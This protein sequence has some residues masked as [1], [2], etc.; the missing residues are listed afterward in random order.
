M[1]LFVRDV[2]DGAGFVLYDLALFVGAVG[3]AYA[4][5]QFV[6]ATWRD[7]GPVPPHRRPHRDPG[8]ARH[9]RQRLHCPSLRVAVRC[10]RP[11]RLLRVARH[12]YRR[13]L[14]G[15]GGL[16]PRGARL[17]HPPP[18][19]E[20]RDLPVDLLAAPAT[21]PCLASRTR[22]ATPSATSSS[23]CRS[24]HRAHEGRPQPPPAWKS[25]RRIRPPAPRPST[26]SS[27][28]APAA[29]S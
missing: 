26:S 3:A 15:R 29:P 12:I 28:S 18:R 13:G 4:V 22:S 1:Y 6:D 8:G 2:D 7:F 21:S 27:R 17:V 24:D 14:R 20:P 16:V 25:P 10:P 19:R 5:K 23:A 9:V 11:A